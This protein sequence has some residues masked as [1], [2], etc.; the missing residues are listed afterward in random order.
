VELNLGVL[1]LGILESVAGDAAGQPDREDAADGHSQ[2]DA[3]D[4]ADAADQA[5]GDPR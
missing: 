1:Q 5:D 3:A 2:P 4:A